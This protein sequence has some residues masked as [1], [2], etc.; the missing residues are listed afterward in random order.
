MNMVVLVY[1]SKSL[2]LSTLP[3][4]APNPSLLLLL[5]LFTLLMFPAALGKD[6]AADDIFWLLYIHLPDQPPGLRYNWS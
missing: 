4:E 6:E 1:F 5:L 3:T 2:N